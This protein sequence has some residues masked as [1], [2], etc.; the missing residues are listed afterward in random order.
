[1][2]RA[3]RLGG[4]VG[5][6]LMA[7]LCLELAACGNSLPGGTYSNTTY[8]FRVSY[9]SGWQVNAS[10]GEVPSTWTTPTGGAT[11]EP[12]P[13]PSQLTAVPL[14]VSITRTSDRASTQPVISAFTITVWDLHDPT[15]AAQAAGWAQNPALHAMTIGG[16]PGYASA[17]IQEPVLPNPGAGGPAATG[18]AASGASAV[19]DTHTDY[20]VVHGGYGYQLGTDAISGDNAAGALQEMLQSFTFTA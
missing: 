19:T 4:L 17:P 9:P 11:P 1:M 16:Q 5:W 2:R 3:T 18:T 15:A 20:Y 12:S 10:S 7:G 8:H 6:L 14:Q 13:T